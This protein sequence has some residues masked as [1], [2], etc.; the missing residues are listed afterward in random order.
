[1]HVQF[2]CSDAGVPWWCHADMLR[3]PP[4]RCRRCAASTVCGQCRSGR[5]WCPPGARTAACRCAS[6]GPII[7][8]LS[9]QGPL[10]GCGVGVVPS[11]RQAECGQQSAAAA[12]GVEVT[13]APGC[14]QVWDLVQQ[15]QQLAAI[16]ED[17]ADSQQRVHAKAVHRSVGWRS[18]AV[19]VQTAVPA[20]PHPRQHGPPSTVYSP[21]W[22]DGSSAL[23][24]AR[25]STI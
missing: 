4:H 20:Q 14:V 24:A 25:C 6:I 15:L 10:S 21:P 1:M 7:T 8:E 2:Q 5:A 16:P 18:A 3:K 12:A 22:G 23:L 9:L 17:S 13:Q 19:S 11:G